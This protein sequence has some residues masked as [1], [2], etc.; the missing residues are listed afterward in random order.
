V[1]ADSP[2]S[3]LFDAFVKS[4]TPT[5]KESLLH[6]ILA[7]ATIAYGIKSPGFKRLFWDVVVPLTW[8]MCIEVIWH[9]LKAAWLLRN[10]SIGGPIRS[11]IVSARGEPIEFPA[12]RTPLYQGKIW[13]LALLVV[14]GCVLCAVMVRVLAGYSTATPPPQPAPLT[15]AEQP[16]AQLLLQLLP[17]SSGDTPT[18][19]SIRADG[20]FTAQI[21]NLGPGDADKLNMKLW[22]NGGCIFTDPP[23]GFYFSDEDSKWVVDSDPN[24]I[25]S[26]QFRRGIT[27]TLSVGCPK[28]THSFILALQYWC[29]TCPKDGTWSE[30]VRVVIKSDER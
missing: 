13:A 29:E 19:I 3:K 7:A 6:V 27:K 23:D 21:N 12:E 18:H 17:V 4:F 28:K 25:P 20:R 9:I 10:E 15:H 14:V 5:L 16:A 11:P 24:M 30:P 1:S 26:I 8:V 22:V 2:P